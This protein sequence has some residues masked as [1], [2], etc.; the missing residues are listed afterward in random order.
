MTL[1]QLVK[2]YQDQFDIVGL[3]NLDDW[4]ARATVERPGIPIIKIVCPCNSR[5]P[6]LVAQQITQLLSPSIQ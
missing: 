6:G 1:E 2:K 3:I 4:Y 5:A